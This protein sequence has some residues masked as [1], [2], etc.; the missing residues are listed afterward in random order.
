MLLGTCWETLRELVEHDENPVGA[1]WKH[2]GNQ[3]NSKKPTPS[4]HTQREIKLGDLGCM[5]A[6]LTSL[7]VKNVKC[8]PL[9]FTIYVLS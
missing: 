2:I 1:C 9:C 8:L 3:Q 7:V 5:L 6:W 4:H